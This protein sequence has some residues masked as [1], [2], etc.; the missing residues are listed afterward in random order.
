MATGLSD[1]GSAPTGAYSLEQFCRAH[2]ISRPFLYKLL[3]Q[4]QGPRITRLGARRVVTIE[5]A[6]TWRRT[7]ARASA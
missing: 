3:K 6:A 4:G 5:D 1:K 7:M 2:S